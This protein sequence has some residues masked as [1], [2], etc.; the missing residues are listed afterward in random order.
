M[1]RILSFM[2]L[3][4]TGTGAIAQSKAT[5]ALQTNYESANSLYFYQST[6]RALNTENNADLAKLIAGVEKITV[7]I[8]GNEEAK[9]QPGQFNAYVKAL[10]TEGYEEMMSVNSQETR[11]GWYVVNGDDPES[12]V[13]VME[14]AG[15][16]TLFDLKGKLDLSLI[17][18]LEKADMGQFMKLLDQSEKGGK[19]K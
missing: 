15:S 1:V 17:T 7:V 19:S 3:V 8:I 10:Q 5:R 4:C 11:F 6:L 12:F 18:S 16:L 9:L 2:L 13:A 14:E